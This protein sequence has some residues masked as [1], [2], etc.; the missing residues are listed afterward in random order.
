[1]ARHRAVRAAAHFRRF[2]ECERHQSSDQSMSSDDCCS[3]ASYVSEDTGYGY[4][5]WLFETLWTRLCAVGFQGQFICTWPSLDLTIAITSSVYTDYDSSC[6]LLALVGAG[7]DF[8]STTS[9][10]PPPPSPI[11]RY[12]R[13]PRRL[14]DEERFRLWSS[15]A[16]AAAVFA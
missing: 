7:L 15:F 2:R 9:P 12:R 8:E 5:Q 6:S 11:Y 10:P 4:M 13:P 1:M 14:C 16:C 3:C